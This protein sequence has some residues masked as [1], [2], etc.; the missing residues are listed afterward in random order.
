[1]ENSFKRF[2]VSPEI[3]VIEFDEKVHANSTS[4][5]VDSWWNG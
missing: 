2:Y 5:N 3:E 1:M 4:V